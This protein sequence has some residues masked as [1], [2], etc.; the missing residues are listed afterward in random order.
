[1]LNV[2]DIYDI[3]ISSG[4]ASAIGAIDRRTSFDMLAYDIIDVFEMYLRALT[5][6]LQT[7][8]INNAEYR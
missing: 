2:I 1:M 5:L 6:I 7:Y 3:N 4:R 8:R